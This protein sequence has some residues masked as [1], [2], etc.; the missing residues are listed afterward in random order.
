MAF[1]WTSVLSHT[2]W[3]NLVACGRFFVIIC[4]V[5]EMIL[6]A[7]GPF[8]ALYLG[9]CVQGLVSAGKL[10]VFLGIKCMYLRLTWKCEV[11]AQLG[12]TLLIWG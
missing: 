1:C 5:L 6:E 8:P 7:K 9:H 2:K 10:S 11:G 12:L 4:M 3:F